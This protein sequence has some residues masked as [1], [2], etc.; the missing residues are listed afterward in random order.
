MD[1]KTARACRMGLHR[2]I[3][4]FS[5]SLLIQTITVGAVDALGGGTSVGIGSH[6]KCEHE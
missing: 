3:F 5:T 4:A 2:F 1:T 6:S